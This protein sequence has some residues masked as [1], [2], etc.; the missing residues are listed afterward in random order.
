[1]SYI[2]EILDEAKMTA[3]KEAKR[4]VLQTI[5]RVAAENAIENAVTV[6][7]IESDEMKGRIIGREDEISGLLKQ[8]PELRSSLTTL[9]RQLSFQL[10]TPFAGKSHVLHYISWLLTEGYILPGLR[11]LLI[12][13]ESRSKRR[14]LK[15]VNGLQL[16][17]E[18]TGYIPS[19]S[20]S[21][22]K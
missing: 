14:Y 16:T 13:Q 4:I 12:R 11:K 9:L 21:L 15:L 10:L 8:Q 3:N 22:V 18:F 1:M 19:L 5:Q 6:F 20:G 17:L 7:H 2:N